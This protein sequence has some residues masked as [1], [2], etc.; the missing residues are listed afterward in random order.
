MTTCQHCKRAITRDDSGEW[1]D[2]NATGDDSLWRYVCDS[3]DTFEAE[4]VPDDAA[5]RMAE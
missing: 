1:I 2:P 4:H 5:E 3:H